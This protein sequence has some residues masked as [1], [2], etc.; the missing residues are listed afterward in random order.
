MTK[1]LNF[2][3]T[4]NILLKGPLRVFSMVDAPFIVRICIQIRINRLIKVLAFQEA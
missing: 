4:A 3:L 2:N 1:P